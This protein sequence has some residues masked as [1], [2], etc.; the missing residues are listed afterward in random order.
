MGRAKRSSVGVMG[1][2]V[3]EPV[4]MGMIPPCDGRRTAAFSMIGQN[5]VCR[6]GMARKKGA[7]WEGSAGRARGRSVAAEQVPGI[8]LFFTSSRQLS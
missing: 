5:G 3:S 6:K 2:R 7:A 1:P 4:C 8:D